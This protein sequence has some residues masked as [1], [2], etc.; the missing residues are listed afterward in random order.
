MAYSVL[1]LGACENDASPQDDQ[2]GETSATAIAP[3]WCD[4]LPRTG[5]A[6]LERVS[7]DSDW[8][9]AWDVGD[10]VIA[11]YE[12][13]QWQEIISYL[14][15]G[16]ERALLFDTGMGIAS[17]ADV[18]GQ[19]TDLPVTVLNSHTHMDHIG[20]N[21]EFGAIMAMDTEFTRGR[22]R[23]LANEQVR[24]ELA[25]EALCGPLP[26]GVTQDAYVTRPWTIT[27]V[28]MDGHVIEL[29]AAHWR[30]S[31]FP[32]HTPDAIALHDAEAGYLWTGD[33]FYEGPI[34]LFAPETEL[35]RYE[36]S[37]ARLA[38]LAPELSR[39]F[40]AHNTPVADPI[41]LVELKE[42]LAGIGAG[43]LTGTSGADGMVRYEAGAFSL[44]MRK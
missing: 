29:G 28:A 27:E 36:T 43:T 31:I 35:A 16:S 11:L 1:L 5:Y 40:P 30:F 19:L 37:V 38:G 42:A 25:P 2:V 6:T 21:A 23:G 14:V 39:V 4:A 44:L 8:F 20:G 26:P 32:G 18:V 17:I 13:R 3:E 15:V 12:P 41:R 7:I 9:E 10:G 22:A 33:S 24:E 34:W